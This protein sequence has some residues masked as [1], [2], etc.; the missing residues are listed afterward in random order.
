MILSFVFSYYFVL[1]ASPFL[2]SVPIQSVLFLLAS[3]HP[4]R[5]LYHTSLLSL[6]LLLLFSLYFGKDL[7]HFLFCLPFSLSFPSILFLFFLCL[8]TF[9]LLFLLFNFFLFCSRR[10]CTFVPLRFRVRATVK[11]SAAFFH[12]ESHQ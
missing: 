6:L 8:P 12:H 1:S 3:L 5:Y 10:Y 11:L 9:L 7:L 4:F 2:C